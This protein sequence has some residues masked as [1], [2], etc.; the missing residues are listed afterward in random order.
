[1]QDASRTQAGRDEILI[2]I[3]SGIP[4]GCYL[5]SN[6]T[7]NQT[8]VTTTI[9]KTSDGSPCKHPWQLSVNDMKTLDS[10]GSLN[11][12]IVNLSTQLSVVTS[13]AGSRT[14][15]AEHESEPDQCRRSSGSISAPVAPGPGC[16]MPTPV[17]VPN[18]ILR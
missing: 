10:G 4:D 5:P 15:S 14:E 18:E 8:T 7:Y 2:Q 17:G 12:G 11:D 16:T 6:F 3:P 13:S 1:M 9:S